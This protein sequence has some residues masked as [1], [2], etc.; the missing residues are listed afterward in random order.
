MAMSERRWFL[1]QASRRD[2]VIE[3]TAILAFIEGMDVEVR[4]LGECLLMFCPFT[5]R[6]DTSDWGEFSH[7]L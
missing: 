2:K 1:D 3:I 7:S 6:D 4:R 5:S